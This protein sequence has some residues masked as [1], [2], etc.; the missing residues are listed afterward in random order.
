MRQTKESWTRVGIVSAIACVM[1]GMIWGVSH[2]FHWRMISL[3]VALSWIFASLLV[4]SLPLPRALRIHFG[5]AV[6]IVIGLL[7]LFF[8]CHAGVLR[9][10]L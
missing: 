3:V 4:I 2:S 5:A 10:P 9:I 7:W 1:S 6:T 8:E